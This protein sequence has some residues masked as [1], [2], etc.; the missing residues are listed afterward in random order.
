MNYIL[1]SGTSNAGKSTTIF[2]ICQALNPSKVW[3]VDLWDKLLEPATLDRIYN[4]TFLIE[5]NGKMILA[6]A[7]APTEQCEKISVIIDILIKLKIKIDFAIVAMRSY[8]KKEGF[9]TRGELTELGTC[10]LDE[11]I[12][13]IEGDDYKQS[14]EWRARI[15]RYVRLIKGNLE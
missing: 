12:W 13:Q 14:K 7:G 2:A 15:N 3:K 5:V 8:E 9:D 4:D 6:V 10:V 1:L 11:Q